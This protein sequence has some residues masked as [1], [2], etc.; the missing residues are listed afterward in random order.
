MGCYILAKPQQLIENLVKLIS[1]TLNEKEIL[2]LSLINRKDTPKNL[3]R[4]VDKI[5]KIPNSSFYYI[6]NCLEDKGLIKRVSR[7]I[8]LTL[9]GLLIKAIFQKNLEK[10]YIAEKNDAKK[11]GG[12]NGQR[13]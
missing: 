7:K 13:N 1:H 4:K 5:L 2:I 8:D 11:Y 6:L 3:K 10:Q 9:L 12:K